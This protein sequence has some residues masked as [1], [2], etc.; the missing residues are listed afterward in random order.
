MWLP[1]WKPGDKF[2]QARILA[3]HV[4]V[5]ALH[6]F[7]SRRSGSHRVLIELLDGFTLIACQL[8]HVLLKLL[9]VV[10]PNSGAALKLGPLPKPPSG[11]GVLFKVEALNSL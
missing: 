10:V 11:F 5:G 4:S 2:C 8:L 3:L 6:T 9:K 1:L 7:Q